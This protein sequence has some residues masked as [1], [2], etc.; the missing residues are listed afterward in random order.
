MNE[1]KTLC[2]YTHSTNGKV[3]YVGSGNR[4][5]PRNL[6]NRTPRWHAH[7]EMH[8]KPEII[9][10]AWTNDRKEAQRVEAEMIENHIPSCNVRKRDTR[11]YGPPKNPLGLGLDP[12]ERAAL[13]KA[14]GTEDRSSA[15]VARRAVL[16]WLKASGYLK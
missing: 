11:K 9:I 6:V 15:Y 5:R 1:R 3:F 14:A 2:V 16:E 10:H 13:D 7:V 12:Q 4:V 8:G